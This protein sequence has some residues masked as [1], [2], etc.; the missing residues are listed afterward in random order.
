MSVLRNAQPSELRR[1][2]DADENQ[3]SGYLRRAFVDDQCS[4]ALELTVAMSQRKF[5]LIADMDAELAAIQP[6]VKQILSATL[7]RQ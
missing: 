4:F 7:K 3:L 2:D 1:W 6:P 5:P